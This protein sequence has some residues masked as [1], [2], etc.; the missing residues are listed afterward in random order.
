MKATNFDRYK[1]VLEDLGY[2]SVVGEKIPETI[3][4]GEAS[5]ELKW[6]IYCAKQKGDSLNIEVFGDEYEEPIQSVR[7]AYF[8][9][10]RL[11]KKFF[12]MDKNHTLT[13]N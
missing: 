5:E 11:L 7:K 3:T 10:K 12:T 8:R 6:H 4:Y 9:A 13:L 2:G 1:S